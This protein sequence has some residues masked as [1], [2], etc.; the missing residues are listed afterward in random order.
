ML[1]AARRS[2]PNFSQSAGSGRESADLLS[3]DNTERVVGQLS[4]PGSR[5][6]SRNKMLGTGKTRGSPKSAG[7]HRAVTTPSPHTAILGE[8]GIQRY[9]LRNL[10]CVVEKKGSSNVTLRCQELQRSLVIFVPETGSPPY[11]MSR[12]PSPSTRP[13]TAPNTRPRS[14]ARHRSRPSS[15]MTS[16]SKFG[17]TGSVTVCPDECSSDSQHAPLSNITNQNSASNIH[18]VTQAW[19]TNS[20]VSGT[21]A[22]DSFETQDNDLSSGRPMTATHI[23]EESEEEEEEGWYFNSFKF[24]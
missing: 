17:K 23:M 4:R 15:S 2:T 14:S 12:P 6:S 24:F 5:V 3:A 10:N 19:G 13:S 20:D 7:H 21:P 16:L 9:L 11:D 1:S 22:Q 18:P 8:S